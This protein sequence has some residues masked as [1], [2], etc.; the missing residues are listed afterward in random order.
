MGFR[1]Q[2]ITHS[3]ANATNE[4]CCGFQREPQPRRPPGT[5]VR[6]SPALDEVMVCANEDKKAKNKTIKALLTR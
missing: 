1:R 3:D 2:T 5:A 6:E 4:G